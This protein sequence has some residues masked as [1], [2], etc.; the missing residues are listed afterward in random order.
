MPSM[1]TLLF[2][3]G[4]NIF[5][6]VTAGFVTVLRLATSSYSP[7]KIKVLTGSLLQKS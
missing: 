1:Q 4:N 3:D 2:Q 5:P 7:S 6:N